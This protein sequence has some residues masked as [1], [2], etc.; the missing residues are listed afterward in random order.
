[1][2]KFPNS[3]YEIILAIITLFIGVSFVQDSD[4]VKIFLSLFLVI[5]Y[6]TKEIFLFLQEKSRKEYEDKLNTIK[7]IETQKEIETIKSEINKIN[8]K[9]FNR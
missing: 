7:N 9:L 4:K 3:Y 1:M 5:A 2:T 6:L 8:F